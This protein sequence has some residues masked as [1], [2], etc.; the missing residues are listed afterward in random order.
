MID[1]GEFQNTSAQDRELIR[2]TADGDRSAF[3]ELMRRHED[4]VFAVCLRMMR[5][6]EAALDAAQDTFLALWRKADRY[7]GDAAVSTWLYRVCVNTCLDQLRKMKRRH[8]EPLPEHHDPPD[9]A[10]QDPFEAADARPMLEAALASI[11]EEF[12]AAVILSDLEGLALAE[13]ADILEIPVGTV[14]SR[15]HRGRR[16]LAEHLGNFPSPPPRQTGSDYA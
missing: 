4:M 16:A 10:A 14:K 7:H 1:R 13:V 11:P 3:T 15:I 6:R 9:A 2:R 12:R 8:T 5:N